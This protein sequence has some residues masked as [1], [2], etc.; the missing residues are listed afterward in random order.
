MLVDEIFA[1]YLY[2]MSNCI[3]DNYYQTVL[4]YVI[5]FR[6]CLNEYGLGKKIESEGIKLEDKP[7]LKLAITTK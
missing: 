1:L 6:E 4:F 7:N 3:N 2:Q 5:Y